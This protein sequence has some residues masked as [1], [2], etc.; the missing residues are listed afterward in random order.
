MRRVAMVLTMLTFGCVEEKMGP[1]EAT[2]IPHAPEPAKLAPPT[3]AVEEPVAQAPQEPA[4][5]RG[6]TR[7]RPGD[8]LEFSWSRTSE[9]AHPAPP[10][11]VAVSGKHPKKVK[12][13]KEAPKPRPIIKTGTLTVTR[14]DPENPFTFLVRIKSG[15]TSEQKVFAYGPDI[16]IDTVV[17]HTNADDPKKKT[18]AAGAVFDCIQSPSRLVAPDA[19]SLALSGGLVSE[20]SLEPTRPGAVSVALTRIGT[21]KPT[22]PAGE[23]AKTVDSFDPPVAIAIQQLQKFGSVDLDAKAGRDAALQAQIAGAAGPCTSNLKN[24]RGR[25]GGL[26]AGGKVE[27][28]LWEQK[29]APKAFDK[30]LRLGLKKVKLPTEET[31]INVSLGDSP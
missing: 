8:L 15:T 6:L 1:G 22:A 21:T 5:P 23:K 25:L 7:A 10:A 28:L 17:V 30:C 16:G 19:A 14:I 18:K 13:L 4:G 29:P 11:S 31:A 26:I 12:E 3:A 20:T 9:P 2:P 27:S 24:R